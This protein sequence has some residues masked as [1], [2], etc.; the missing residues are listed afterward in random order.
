MD[1]MRINVSKL[2]I[3]SRDALL[4]GSVLFSAQP[5]ARTISTFAWLSGKLARNIDRG[6]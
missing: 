6:K 5:E 4:S 2:R 3:L 1:D